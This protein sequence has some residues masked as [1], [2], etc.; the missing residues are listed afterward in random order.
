M[1]RAIFI[2]AVWARAQWDEYDPEKARQG[3]EVVVKMN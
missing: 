1:K 2:S 3:D